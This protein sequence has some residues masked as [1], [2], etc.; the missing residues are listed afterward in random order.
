MFNP[1]LCPKCE[2]L[3]LVSKKDVFVTCP[4]CRENIS[5][6]EGYTK[7][8]DWIGD[9]KNVNDVIALCLELEDNYGPEVSTAILVLAEASFPLN[10][11]IAWLNLKFQDY[12]PMHIKNH[13][14]RFAK[15]KAKKYQ[16]WA[17]EFLQNAMVVKNMEFADMFG[18]YID[19]KILTKRKNEYK[20]MLAQ[21]RAAYTKTST[22]NPALFTLYAF[23]SISS[24]VNVGMMVW[25]LF[26]RFPIWAYPLIAIGVM[27]VQLFIFFLHNRIF[28]NRENM[29]DRERMFMVTYMSSIAIAIGGVFLGIFINL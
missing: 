5:G 17:E 21:M 25:F 6:D 11:Q 8:K 19:N 28:G 22:G 14:S 27:A 15:I 12:E 23:Y 18:H 13:L 3:I 7:L 26:M 2:K 24:L 4:L 16:P 9:P 10:E 1:A 20:E 29:S